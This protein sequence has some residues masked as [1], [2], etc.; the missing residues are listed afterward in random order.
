MV[1]VGGC[2]TEE[3]ARS[4]GF[5]V[6]GRAETRRHVDCGRQVD[7]VLWLFFLGGCLLLGKLKGHVFVFLVGQ[8]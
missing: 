2:E 8:F 6:G 5:D 4:Y 3:V 1:L 7:R